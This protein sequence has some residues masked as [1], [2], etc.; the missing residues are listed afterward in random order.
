MSWNMERHGNTTSVKGGEG[1]GGSKLQHAVL[2]VCVC[3]AKGCYSCGVRMARWPFF[4]SPT[5][6]TGAALCTLSAL[7]LLVPP[8]PP[9]PHPH[10]RVR[11]HTHTAACAWL[12]RNAI[13]F[14]AGIHNDANEVD[15]VGTESGE[16]VYVQQQ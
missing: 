16:P 2:C 4:G 13:T 14:G 5:F 12:Q 3:R 10:T 9:T 6:Y 11:A 7:F 8:P 1:E 15:W